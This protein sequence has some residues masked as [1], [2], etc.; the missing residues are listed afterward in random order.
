VGNA[1]P[2]SLGIQTKFDGGGKPVEEDTIMASPQTKKPPQPE[3]QAKSTLTLPEGTV[4]TLAGLLER[5]SVASA[6]R[7]R[8]Q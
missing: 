5:L 8:S 3:T 7:K 1:N 4:P 6:S 2:A